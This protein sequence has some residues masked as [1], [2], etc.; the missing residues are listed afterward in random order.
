LLDADRIN[1]AAA[2][3]GSDDPLDVDVIFVID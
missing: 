3:D 1:N 2:I